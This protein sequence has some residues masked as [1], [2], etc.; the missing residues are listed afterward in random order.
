MNYIQRGA[1]PER[2]QKRGRRFG[3]WYS[4]GSLRRL[5]LNARSYFPEGNVAAP[6]SFCA[7]FSGLHWL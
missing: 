2:R 7:W 1:V 6:R 5:A 4:A 3:N